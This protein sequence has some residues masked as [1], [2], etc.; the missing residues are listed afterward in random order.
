MRSNFT[1]EETQAILAKHYPWAVKV[2][3]YDTHVSLWRMAKLMRQ[4]M[5]GK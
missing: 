2:V 4:F 3:T 1:V 5:G